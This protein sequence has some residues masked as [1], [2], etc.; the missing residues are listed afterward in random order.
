MTSGDVFFNNQRDAYDA[1]RPY[2]GVSE[3]EPVLYED[4]RM[5]EHM[6]YMAELRLSSSI[7]AEAKHRLVGLFRVLRGAF[8]DMVRL[9]SKTLGSPCAE[10]VWNRQE[11]LCDHQEPP[12]Q[13]AEASFY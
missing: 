13:R 2:S 8:S 6:F 1:I 11:G 12:S 5:I 4:L 3:Q 9:I 10:R 7:S